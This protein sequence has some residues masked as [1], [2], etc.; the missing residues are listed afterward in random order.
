MSMRIVS[1]LRREKLTVEEQRSERLQE[2]IAVVRSDEGDTDQAKE[3]ELVSNV[4]LSAPHPCVFAPSSHPIRPL[5]SHRI[6]STVYLLPSILSQKKN[7][8]QSVQNRTRFELLLF[9]N[10]ILD[11]DKKQKQASGMTDYLTFKMWFLISFSLVVCVWGREKQ[12]LRH[13]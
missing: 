8:R 4:M 2:A 3:I 9:K 12:C 11:L 1:I 10:F 13:C 7:S 5:P 6:P